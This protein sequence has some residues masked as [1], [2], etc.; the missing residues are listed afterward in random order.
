M[1]VCWVAVFVLAPNRWSCAG[2]LF[3]LG[4]QLLFKTWKEMEAKVDDFDKVMVV[5]RKQLLAV[6]DLPLKQIPTTVE[7]F[8]VCSRLSSAFACGLVTLQ[9]KAV[10]KIFSFSYFP[11]FEVKCA[12]PFLPLG[13][14]FSLSLSYL[15]FVL[16]RGVL[17][18]FPF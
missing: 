17:A 8:K 6:L 1:L 12:F 13:N 2:Q 15:F 10:Q 14:F 3:S 7:N 5:V 18:G 4:I 11:Y 9:G 16:F